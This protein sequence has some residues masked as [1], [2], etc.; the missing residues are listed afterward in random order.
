MVKAVLFLMIALLCTANEPSG[1]VSKGMVYYKY[2]LKEPTGMRGDLFAKQHTTQ[3]WLMRFE[4]NATVLKKE[5]LA[6]N[7]QLKAFVE[8]PRFLEIMPHIKAFVVHYAK[9]K[10]NSA[11]CE[12]EE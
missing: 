2:L 9:D 1:S 5:L 12:E 7:P 8:S 4:N 10:T 6:I 11:Q 3:E